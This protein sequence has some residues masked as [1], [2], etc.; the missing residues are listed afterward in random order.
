[1]SKVFLGSLGALAIL[2]TTSGSLPA[3]EEP[4][5]SAAELV[6]R[7]GDMITWTPQAGSHHRLRFGGS[8]AFKGAPLQL[9]KFEDV[10]KVLENFNPPPPPPGAGGLVRWPEATPVTAKVK[11]DTGTPAVTE[12]FF[13]C[14]NDFH[15]DLMVTATFKVEPAISGQPARNI[16]IIS[17][18]DNA[19]LRWVL[20]T[21]PGTAAG[22]RSLRRP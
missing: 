18:P 1:M 12:F 21:T 5:A 17:A 4:P 8:V 11:A 2:V 16:Q 19:P 7:A 6:L 15:H 13:T 22:D 20:Q 3:A 14:G 10:Q 9:T